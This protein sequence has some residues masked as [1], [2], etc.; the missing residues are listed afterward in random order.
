MQTNA[1]TNQYLAQKR[2]RLIGTRDQERLEAELEIKSGIAK[3]KQTKQNLRPG[4]EVAQTLRGRAQSR[5]QVEEGCSEAGEPINE[6]K[7]NLFITVECQN[8]RHRKS[9]LDAK[10][11]G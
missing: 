3:E 7:G 4:T 1:R 2:G 8:E 10:I 5:V 9:S 11:D 6:M